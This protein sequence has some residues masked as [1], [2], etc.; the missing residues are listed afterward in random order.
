MMAFAV[1]AV[2]GLVLLLGFHKGAR[3]SLLELAAFASV[4]AMVQ[5]VVHLTAHTRQLPRDRCVG[6]NVEANVAREC[7]HNRATRGQGHDTETRKQVP[8]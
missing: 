1:L 7:Y 4:V 6:L 8:R 2:L 3:A 5:I